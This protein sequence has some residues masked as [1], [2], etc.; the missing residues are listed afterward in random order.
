MSLWMSASMLTHRM[1]SFKK[2]KFYGS[3][4]IPTNG[5][6]YEGVGKYYTFTIYAKTFDT[7][8]GMITNYGKGDF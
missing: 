5:A 1:I 3:N 6:G 4:L 8:F 7:K 2:L